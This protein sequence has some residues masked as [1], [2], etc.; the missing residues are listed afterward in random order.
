MKIFIL[1]L[2]NLKNFLLVS[3]KKIFILL[4]LRAKKLQSTALLGCN[5]T[6][7]FSVA[8]CSSF[9]LKHMISPYSTRSSCFLNRKK[10][11]PIQTRYMMSKR[12]LTQ[13]MNSMYKAPRAQYATRRVCKGEKHPTDPNALQN[14]PYVPLKNKLIR[15]QEI[16][17][18]ECN[19]DID[20]K[21]KSCTTLCS[22]A[23]GPKKAIGHL[24]HGTPQ[25][26]YAKTIEKLD[27]VDAQGNNKDQ[28]AVF[29]ENAHNTGSTVTEN[30][31]ATSY[32]NQKHIANKI[33]KHEDKN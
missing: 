7:D 18:Q 22:T 3:Y 10:N 4:A 33:I 14:N 2:K 30:V 28:N 31:Q 12:V 17:R 27:S 29:Y 23:K 19:D 15:H 16:T 9:H 32:I 13:A 21:E 1:N 6:N 5:K 26:P 24:T 25:N 11:S 8:L 20:C